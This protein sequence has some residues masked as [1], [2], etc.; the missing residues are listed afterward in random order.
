[1][2]RIMLVNDNDNNDY[3][4]DNDYAKDS[5]GSDNID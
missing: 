5:N 4:N 3:D 1:M 2:I